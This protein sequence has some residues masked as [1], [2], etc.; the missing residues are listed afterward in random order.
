MPQARKLLFCAALLLAGC[1]SQGG[2]YGSKPPNYRAA[3][4]GSPPRL[5]ALHAQADQ[6]LPGG[7][8]AFSARI[9]GLRGIPVVV[10]K[11][12][13]WCGPCRAEFPFFQRQS[14]ARGKRVAFLGLDSDDSSGS[15]KTFLGEF[16]ISYPSYTD[17]DQKV[18]KLI[19]ATLGFPSTAFYDRTGKLAFT[20]TGGYANERLL[21]AD[22]ARYS[23]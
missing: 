23:Q 12:A 8:G 15:A 2:N 5:A 3:L 4:A 16:P 10:N 20:H 19:K 13:S 6:L 18:A 14:A 7:A 22:I 11:W 17:P 21:A 1:G 9:A